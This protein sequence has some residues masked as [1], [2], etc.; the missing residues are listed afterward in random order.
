MGLHS[1]ARRQAGTLKVKLA[2]L[3]APALA[4]LVLAAPSQAS[5]QFQ[6]YRSPAKSAQLL[7]VQLNRGIDIKQTKVSVFN[8]TLLIGNGLVHDKSFGWV[9]FRIRAYKVST[10]RLMGVYTFLLWGKWSAPARGFIDTKYP[11]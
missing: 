9:P 3:A 11:N 7:Q 2:A 5:T 8:P 1:A 6:R 4:A 10:Y